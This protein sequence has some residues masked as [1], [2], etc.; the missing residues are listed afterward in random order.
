M[1]FIRCSINQG[2]NFN[3]RAYDA[4]VSKILSISRL[5]GIKL[6]GVIL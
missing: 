2:Y 4:G 5:T 6:N 3:N 1:D